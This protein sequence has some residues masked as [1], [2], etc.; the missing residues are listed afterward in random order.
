[1]MPSQEHGLLYGQV[2]ATFGVCST[3]Y[4]CFGGDGS[5][6]LTISTFLT[7][8]L[9][10]LCFYEMC[11]RY[12]Q[13]EKELQEYSSLLITR[14]KLL[15]KTKSLL[16]ISQEQQKRVITEMVN[17]YNAEIEKEEHEGLQFRYPDIADISRDRSFLISLCQEHN[18]DIELK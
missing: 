14:L 4:S 3:V 18:I 16:G 8:G 5:I 10:C 17:I 15:E 9:S 1:M 12:Q 7:W 2:F 13:R 6:A 11:C